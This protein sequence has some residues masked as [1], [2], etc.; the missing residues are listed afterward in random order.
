MSKNPTDRLRQRELTSSRA[1][2]SIFAAVLVVVA[3]IYALFEVA[4][5]S[6]GQPALLA[7]PE[8]W[9]ASIE[10]LPRTGDPVLLVAGGVL[11]LLLG[12]IFLAQGLVRGR[13]ARHAIS[14]GESVIV[15]DDQVIAATLA[16]RARTE[17]GVVPEQVLVV[18]NHE[19]VEV[20][21]RPTSGSPVDAGQIRA[22]VEDEL[23]SNQIIPMPTVNVRV[24]ETGVIGQ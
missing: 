20:Q 16:R 7:P 8:T 13:R 4:L 15:V 17:A 5:K 1:P 12:L 24:A 18:V 22:A 3:C 6:L 9:W 19:R 14:Y 2:A 23:R 10:N 11:L 21:L